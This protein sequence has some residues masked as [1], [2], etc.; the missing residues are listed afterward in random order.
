M[1]TLE[2]RYQLLVRLFYPAGYRH[3]REAEIVGTYLELAPP[4]KRRPSP[5]DVADLA[6]GGARQHLRATEVTEL[7]PGL[8]LAGLLAMATATALAAIWAVVESAP[9]P[10]D[11]TWEIPRFGP[12]S[13]LGAIVWAV[14]L[15][16]AFLFSVRPQWSRAAIGVA[17]LATVAVVPLS[18]VTGVYRPPLYVLLPQFALGFLALGTGR[19]SLIERLLPLAAGAAAAAISRPGFDYAIGYLGESGTYTMTATG[20]ILLA[21]AIAIAVGLGVTGHGRGGWA[22]LILLGPIGLITLQELT[23][24]LT[25]NLYGEWNVT[26]SSLAATA[27][28]V[29]VA[30][31]GLLLLALGLQRRLTVHTR[32]EACGSPVRGAQRYDRTHT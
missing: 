4:G 2:H 18:A 30:G 7:R 16:A 20:L 15:L 12:F 13:S 9:L 17:L 10:P 1:S 23:R 8:R 26:Y 22:L 25:G 31:A 14:W 19:L 3:E 27:V 28:L 6:T 11:I 32:C 24:T 21:V 5:R 29:T